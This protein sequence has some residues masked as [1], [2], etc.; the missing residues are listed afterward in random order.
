MTLRQFSKY[1][2]EQQRFRE[3]LRHMA[4]STQDA[5]LYIR[6]MKELEKVDSQMDDMVLQV[7]QNIRTTGRIH[8]KP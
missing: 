4:D 6:I 7:G 1:Y 3:R 2:G 5:L 8:W